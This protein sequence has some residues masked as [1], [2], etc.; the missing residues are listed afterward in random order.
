[1][2]AHDVA[3]WDIGLMQRCVLFLAH[4]AYSIPVVLGTLLVSS[5]A[6][7]LLAPRL[8]FPPALRLQRC[9]FAVAVVLVLLLF[10]LGP[11]FNA[12]L[13]LAFTARVGITMALLAPAGFVMGMPF[14]LGLAMAEKLGTAVVPWAWGINGGMS[15][16]GSV[17]AIIV[18]MGTGF[19]W[20]L[21]LAAMLYVVAVYAARRAAFV[22]R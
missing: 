18:A 3:L 17:L 20:V 6:G 10:A 5:G 2:T 1:M 14:P 16:L 13:G 4:P 7:S 19:T 12:C 8:P 21:A 22:P 15:V 11:V 9:L